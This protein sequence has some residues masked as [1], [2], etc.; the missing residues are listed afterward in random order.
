MYKVLERSI[1]GRLNLHREETTRDKQVGFR[2]DRPT[3][4]QV[5]DVK[6][7][8]EVWQRYSKPLQWAFLDFK[9]T[10]NSPH[11]VRL[12]NSLRSGGV[13]HLARPLK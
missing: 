10:F 8:V 9:A 2:A 5:F 4:D 6:R 3:I 11:R 1:L 13:Q 7:V 12:L